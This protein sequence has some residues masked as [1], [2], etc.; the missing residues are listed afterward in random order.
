MR[1]LR[2]LIPGSWRH[3]VIRDL[4]DEARVNG[5]GSF[6]MAGELRRVGLRLRPVV[7][8]DSVMADLRYAIASLWR[9]KA[10]ALGAVL[11]FAL[12]IGVNVAVFSVVDR[13]MIRSLPYGDPDSLVVMGE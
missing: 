13:M 3:A 10:F 12:G 11:T 1:L 4:E 6:W 7:N 2:L 5:K 8:G 9:S